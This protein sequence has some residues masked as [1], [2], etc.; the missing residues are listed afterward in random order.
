[1]LFRSRI[2]RP[3]V[4]F[5][6]VHPIEETDVDTSESEEGCELKSEPRKEDLNAS[7]EYNALV[8]IRGI[9]G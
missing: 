4:R 2:L 6:L 1:M 3:G 7:S 9:V 5:E 8:E